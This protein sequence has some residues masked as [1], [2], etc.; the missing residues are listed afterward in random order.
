MIPAPH[1][2]HVL[3]AVT[4]MTCCKAASAAGP[5]AIW[6]LLLIACGSCYNSAKAAATAAAGAGTQHPN[7]ASEP[8]TP[9]PAADT[10][11]PVFPGSQFPGF[12]GFSTPAAAFWA[13]PNQG[14]VVPKAARSPS[15][16]PVQA[17]EIK[18]DAMFCTHRP[19][20]DPRNGAYPE[21]CKN[22]AVGA[23]CKGKCWAG[24]AGAPSTV[25]QRST[26]GVA[27]WGPD[28][29]TC[30]R[31]GELG[32]PSCLAGWHVIASAGIKPVT[33]RPRAS[34]SPYT[35]IP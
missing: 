21:S 35:L 15:A 23:R 3:L 13:D 20:R 19:L 14:P 30:V 6:L 18:N 25:C 34:D 12:F 5:I 26:G 27:D 22:L 28:Q 9:A 7:K 32:V 33:G 4:S 11:S 8:S 10:W 16:K 24:Y 2:S 1:Y 31:V 17:P 29:G